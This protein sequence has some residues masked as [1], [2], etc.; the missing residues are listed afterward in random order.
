MA[1]I[2]LRTIGGIILSKINCEICGTVYPDNATVC[3]IC[4]YPRNVGES[5]ELLET[6]VTQTAVRRSE[7]VKGGR[8]SNKNVKK[9]QKTSETVGQEDTARVHRASAEDAPASGK[10]SG[11]HKK[12]HSKSNRGLVITV[13]VLLVAILLVGAYIGMRF[14]VGR[15]AYRETM[16]PTGMQQPATEPAQTVP[17]DTSVLCTDI[18]ISDI[19][20]E[21]GIEF[22][23]MGRAWRVNVTLVPANTTDAVTYTSEDENVAVVNVTDGRVEILSIGPGSTTVTVTCGAISKS[24]RVLCSFEG[25]TV[26][27]T[28]ESTEP[29]E[30]TREEGVLALDVE[31]ISFFAVDE[32][33]T[34][35]PGV[36]IDP[37]D[38]SWSSDDEEVAVVD[39][40]GKVTAV[41]P[42]TC[43]ITA[44]YEGEEAVCI[45]R[46]NIDEDDTDPSEQTEET[47]AVEDAGPPYKI[48]HTDVSIRIG[49]SF[50]LTLRD[51]NGDIV[52]V[53][54]VGDEDVEIDGN[55]ITGVG[56]GKVY[57]RCTHNGEEFECIVR[58]G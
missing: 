30:D 36:G 34:I 28:E 31:D 35:D 17:V 33:Y 16:V 42:G 20:L 19:D 3:P 37:E 6:E 29:T 8:F 15:D 32:H 45:I 10:K 56:A 40:S 23:G 14:F 57:V 22:L 18:L 26:P 13:I 49:E 11:K 48:S 44:E 1:Q 58:V 39:D 38:V 41:G 27:A 25:E 47:E 9:R 52:D 51:K 4:G 7:P 43:E 55:T 54:W 5:V 53:A 46:C 12:K 2:A 24:F 21:Q 50:K